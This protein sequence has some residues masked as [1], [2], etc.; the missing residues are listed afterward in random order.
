M[1][2][3]YTPV[4]KKYMYIYIY[5]YNTSSHYKVVDSTVINRNVNVSIIQCV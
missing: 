5:I 4:L 2:H 1:N 3:K